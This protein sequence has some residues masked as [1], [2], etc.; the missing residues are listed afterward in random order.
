MPAETATHGASTAATAT[1]VASAAAVADEGAE[2]RHRTSAVLLLGWVAGITSAGICLAAVSL[3]PATEALDLSPFLRSAAAAAPSLA[4]A[5]TAVAVGVAADRLGRRRLLVW[6]CILAAA[7]CLAVVLV[8]ASP[9]YLAGVA[10]AGVAYGVMLTGTYAYLAAVAPPGGLGHAIGVWG[11][12]SILVGTAASLAGGL[13]ADVDWRLL[14]LVVPAMCLPAAPLLP[15]LLP[16]MSRVREGSVDWWGLLLLGLGLALLITGLLVVATDP[17]LPVAWALLAGAT[18]LLVAWVLVERRRETPSFPVRLFRCRLFVAGVLAGLFVNGA[19]AAP[20]ISLSDYLQYEKQGSVLA[21]TLG[22]QPFYLIGALAWFVAGRQ[23]SA[24]RAPRFVIAL[25]AL[26]A[27]AGFVALL[28]LD[29]TSA[30]W[31]ILPGSL[32]IGYGTNVA[33]TGQAQVFLDAAPPEAFGAVTGSKLT[34]GQLGYSVGMLLTTMLLGG[35]TARGVLHGLTGQGMSEA[36]ASATLSALNSAL[37]S[38]QPPKVD[39]LSQALGIT[40]A[41]FTVAFRVRMLVGA[42]AMLATAAFVWVLM[43]ERRAT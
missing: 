3:A 23:L 6:S 4:M 28:P 13:L 32:L 31:V 25:G 12:S 19:Y 43:R 34:I 38:G 8:P 10:A 26:L 36:D 15:R 24:G 42:A 29:R 2:V 27:A 17:G 40:A 1:Q 16:R 14:F 35:L 5:A 39:D 22:L 30:Y 37:L 20:V 11:T 41:A 21:A 33:L 18:A 7:A 9:V